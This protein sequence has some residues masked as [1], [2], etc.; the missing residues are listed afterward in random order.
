MAQATLRENRRDPVNMLDG[1]TPPNRKSS[2]RI[3][4][5]THSDHYYIILKD[6]K[7][8]IMRHEGAISGRVLDYGCGG[9]PY[10][11][12]FSH[13]SDYVG[14]DFPSNHDADII[15][16]ADGRL[17][18]TLNGFDAV[19]STGVLHLVPDVSSY[20]FECR[21]VL[22]ERAGKLLLTTCGVW[23]YEPCPRDLYRWTHEGLVRVIEQ[24]GF[25]TCHV[26][27]VTTGLK[28]VLQILLCSTYHHKVATGWPKPA[29]VLNWGFNYLADCLRDEPD[30]TRALHDFPICY[31]YLGKVKT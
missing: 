27:P 13:A 23:Q 1:F 22:S 7:N 26:E 2:V 16:D 6:L 15:L 4:S 10:E 3:H 12:F 29:R 5:P 18:R 20:L 21:R 19:L 24:H 25:E 28:A 8:A 30:L 17:P 9:K 14:A 31:L 11:R